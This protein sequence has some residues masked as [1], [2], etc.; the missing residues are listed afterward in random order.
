[1]ISVEEALKRILD[2]FQP[3]EIEEIPLDIANGRV[4]AKPVHAKITQPPFD[5]SSMDGY[6]LRQA[7]LTE[8][9]SFDVIGEAAAGS[10]FNRRVEMGQTVRIF[11]G[12]PVPEGADFVVIQEDVSRDK[13][14]IT[15]GAEAPQGPN[16]RKAGQ[17]FNLGT[18][19]PAPQ[20]LSP[21]K[22]ALLASMNIAKLPVYRKPVVALVATGDELVLP[23]ETPA[24]DQIV[25]SNAFG[26]AA[27]FDTLGCEIRRLPVAR[28]TVESLSLCL[29][30][31]QDADLIVTIGGASVG[32]H[33]IVQDVAKSLGLKMAFYKVAMRPGKPLMAGRLG[34]SV[35]IGLPG[36]P[37][38]SM[39]C[40]HVFLAPA[41]RK[42]T[43]MGNGAL[44]RQRLP[45]AEPLGTNGPREHYMRARLV[46][47]RDG[48]GLV[49]EERQDSALLS[50]LAGA[51]GLLVRAPN[52][53]ARKIGDLVDFIRLEF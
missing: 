15:L 33:D 31:A 40:A 6:A 37:V 3:L 1:M 7:D 52:D 38:S 32:D 29:K 11:T 51:D 49:A 13:N 48:P 18:E 36:N 4:L 28:D 39:I 43:G 27:L 8:I 46:E 45:L 34:S 9:T 24:P 41:I 12:A 53:P 2:L 35:M 47:G 19:F 44:K 30:L 16:I 26:L 10:G 50:V 20:K 17:D 22:I 25:A 21:A 5:A 42:M 23:G 14:V